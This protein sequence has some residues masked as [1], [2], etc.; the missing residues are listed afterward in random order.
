MSNNLLYSIHFLTNNLSELR[1]TEIILK[2]YGAIVKQLL[3]NMNIAS[4]GVAC[5][6]IY[7]TILT[8]QSETNVIY[9]I[10]SKQF[11]LEG[12]TLDSPNDFPPS[13]KYTGIS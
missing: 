4:N 10:N 5:H 3:T 13:T 9:K 8:V 6:N 2:F 7:L 11:P 12:I 1:A